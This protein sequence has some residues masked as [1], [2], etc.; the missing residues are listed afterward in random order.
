MYIVLDQKMDLQL[1]FSY[2]LVNVIN[3]VSEIIGR[4]VKKFIYFIDMEL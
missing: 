3:M 4:K 1:Q 2:G